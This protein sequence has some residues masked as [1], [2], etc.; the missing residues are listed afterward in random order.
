MLGTAAE[1]TL[2]QRVAGAAAT[3]APM[4][5][6]YGGAQQLGGTGD[7]ASTAE[8]TGKG[9][10]AGTVLG[11]AAEGS[12]AAI[13]K[14][15]G[16]LKPT[17]E[18]VKNFL[19]QTVSTTTRVFKNDAPDLI[20]K[21]GIIED[22]RGKSLR[23]LTESLAGMQGVK[24]ANEAGQPRSIPDILAEIKPEALPKT[25]QGYLQSAKAFAERQESVA[26]ALKQAG[27]EL[28]AQQEPK[29]QALQK[30]ATPAE[31][32][33]LT[34]QLYNGQSRNVLLRIKNTPEAQRTPFQAAVWDFAQPIREHL[35][36]ISRAAGEV[37]LNGVHPDY[38]PRMKLA[39]EGEAAAVEIPGDRGTMDEPHGILTQSKFTKKRTA[40]LLANE[41]LA[42]Y[43][44]PMDSFKAMNDQLPDMLEKGGGAGKYV[45][46]GVLNPDYAKGGFLHNRAVDPGRPPTLF[47]K[48][49]PEPVAPENMGA[50]HTV[51][52]RAMAQSVEN[53]SA[54]NPLVQQHLEAYMGRLSAP[55]ERT[56]MNR[57]MSE[58]NALGLQTSPNQWFNY[59]VHIP[60]AMAQN[61]IKSAAQAMGDVFLKG[62]AKE[63]REVFMKSIR[64]SL[65]RYQEGKLAGTVEAI[66]SPGSGVA[67]IVQKFSDRH[68]DRAIMN[69]DRDMMAMLDDIER[70]NPGFKAEV[71]AAVK[72]PDQPTA[73]LRMARDAYIASVMPQSHARDA[74]LVQHW[75]NTRN[76]SGINMTSSLINKSFVLNRISENLDAMLVQLPRAIKAGDRRV[77]VDAAWRIGKIMALYGVLEPM[78]RHALKSALGE[79]D[80]GQTAQRD[81]SAMDR[82]VL[83]GAESAGIPLGVVGDPKGVA[84]KP[85][86]TLNA[87]ARQIIPGPMTS[88][89]S[90][91][92][93][94]ASINDP[95]TKH[96]Q[97]FGEK[98]ERD[99]PGG[100]FVTAGRKIIKKG[101]KAFQEWQ[102]NPA[103]ENEP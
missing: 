33:Q 76:K 101:Y 40:G 97:T 50:P 4:G 82:A 1:R 84:R 37:G 66:K 18:G 77:I 7:L 44:N 41:Q 6:L 60:Q 48:M 54:S 58:I 28:I 35:D 25:E 2:A 51:M 20:Y 95:P 3:G 67:E 74:N 10:V 99:L 102:K 46:A 17:A 36:E 53:N 49:Q 93:D 42:D 94:L 11:G 31:L 26:A 78:A 8:A 59:A 86:E 39:R 87:A 79:E 88:A 30:I 92:Q 15:A 55:V 13:G 32:E 81:P 75:L 12:G 91:L 57:S 19:G 65:E 103:H 72:N 70:F 23:E 71:Q 9:F 38:W 43:H 5:A 96:G 62:G 80:H 45:A 90:L 22:L 68:A 34:A 83:I 47:G 52:Q 21:S 64:E 69:G 56:G 63:A 89:A 98:M 100:G 24:V 27:E 61:D 85:R 16:K 73:A 29:W 14:V